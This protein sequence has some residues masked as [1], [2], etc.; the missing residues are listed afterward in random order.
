M[1]ENESNINEI[2]MATIMKIILLIMKIIMK[3]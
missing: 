2:I 3:N 1:Y